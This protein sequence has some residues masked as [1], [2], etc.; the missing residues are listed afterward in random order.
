MGLKPSTETSSGIGFSSPRG[1]DFSIL[2]RYKGNDLAPQAKFFKVLARYKGDDLA[3]AI[4]FKLLARCKGDDLAPH[5]IFFNV[6]ENL[7]VITL[8]FKEMQK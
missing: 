6:L 2:A 1:L 3:Q 4:F 5:A 8:F 7:K